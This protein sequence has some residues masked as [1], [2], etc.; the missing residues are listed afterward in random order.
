MKQKIKLSRLHCAGCAEALSEKIN[1][2]EE[3]ES[4]E[5]DFSSKTI[6]FET[7][8]KDLDKTQEK[9]IQTVKLFDSSI[10][11]IDTTEEEKVEQREKMRKAWSISKICLCIL[12]CVVAILIPEKILWL[13]ICFFVVSYLVVGA[14]ILFSAI[15]NLFKGKMLDENFLMSVATIGAFALQE[16]IEAIAVMFLY[17]VGELF[18]GLAVDK[19]KKRIK[20]L[21]MIKAN[22]ANLVT[23][24][25][26]IVVDV[27]EVKAGS[28]IRVKPGEKIPL[29]GVVVQGS[30]YLNTS[31]IT[32]ESAEI[33]V[34][35]NS[36]VLSGSINGESVLL[37]KVLKEE[38]QSTVSK[39]VKM[40][41][42][43]SAKKAKTEKFITKF[44]KIYTPIVVGLAVILAIVPPIFGEPFVKWLYTALVFLVVSCPCA[45]VLSIPLG[46]FAGIGA[47]ARNGILVK[48]GNYLE[49]LAKANAVVFDKTGTLTEGDFEISEIFANENSSKQEVLELIAYAESFSNHKIAK[50]IVKAYQKDIN[51]AW[52]DLYK[53]IA[54]KGVCA[55][56]FG[57][58]CVVGNEELLRENNI[59][60]IP[61]ETDGTVVY[62]AK[63]GEFLG[64]IVIKDKIKEDS[65]DAVTNLQ[66]LGLK[67]V[68]M[69]GDNSIVSQSVSQKLGIDEYYASLLPHQKVEKLEEVQKRNKT[70]FVGDG[71]NDAP[72]L[73]T[74][75]VG[76]S[77]GGVGSDIAIETADV[78]LMT[79]QPSKLV[80]AIKI[81]KKTSRISIENIVFIL[82]VKVVVMLL[83]IL[84][85][86][87]MW[88]AI[89]ADV[90]VCLL[91]V[92]NSLRALVHSSKQTKV[93]EK[94]SS[95]KKAKTSK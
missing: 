1:E 59:D 12:F 70:I 30:S 53:E 6:Y 67:T 79:D 61:A 82:L 77:M 11:V 22:T 26:E 68:M 63:S 34:C 20:S 16:Y 14:E 81:A 90:G 21:L 35:E 94:V 92:L 66:S 64:Y 3:V 85:I 86:S 75:D 41:E 87:G 55:T 95:L 7:K 5:I 60:F 43:A 18:E 32:G 10:K 38:E 28:L 93:K 73:A 8:N 19:S 91:A 71:I 78:V 49:L 69:T 48:G 84:G 56:L 88:L 9:I 83:S 57:E 62:L 89:F 42:N 25:G 76:V 29:D 37:C 27:S 51:T 80:S 52:V 4:A 46:Y 47:S 58:E 40:V 39:I 45:L 15:K 44:S 33:F 50:S 36:E 23:G 31:A 54:G 74:S 65:F 17:Q 13:K 24:D 72:A 2:L